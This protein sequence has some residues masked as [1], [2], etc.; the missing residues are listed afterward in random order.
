MNKYD[1]L[2]RII[3]QNVGGKDNVIGLT[4]CVT[5]LRFKLK[6]ESKAN[7][8][9]LKK[10]DG[11][12]TVIQSGGQYQV[13]IGNH[14][15]DVFDA[16]NEIGGFAAKGGED[17][18]KEK[19]S[20]GAAFIDMISGIFAPTLGV[21][22]ATGMIKGL[23]AMCTFFKILE[24]TSGTYQILYAAADS[25]F[26]FLP[27]LL[28]FTA[29]KKFGLNHFTGMAIAGAL[30]YPN[31]VALS[32]GEVLSTVFSGTM[33]ET[34]VYTKFLG[35]PVLLPSGGYASTV[36]PIIA[37]VYIASKL[38]KLFKKI[39]PDVVK[40]FLVPMCVLLVAVPV[41]F[42]LIG[43]VANWASAIVGSTTSWLYN[44]SPIIEGIFVG[45]FWQIFVMFGLH[46]GLIPIFILNL[47][48]KG[49]DDVLQPFFVASF[50]QTAVVLAMLIKTKDKKLKRL[51]I[52]AFI[53][54][55]FGV[56]EPAI[57]GIT[58]PRKKPFVIS[59]IGGAIGGGIMG[60]ANVN[61]YML[62]GMGVFG[63]PNYINPATND[64]SGLV[65]AAVAVAVGTV[66]SFILTM[67][68]YKD[69][70][71]D[72]SSNTISTKA[73]AASKPGETLVSPVAGTVKDL[74]QVSD[75]A[76][77]QGILG[78]G[79]AIT[80]S[81]GKIYAP[82]D[83]V[84]TTFFPTG[85]A[86]GLTTNNGAELLIHVGMDTVQLEGKFFQP[87]AKQ[88]D[89]VTAGQLLLEFDVEAIKAAGYSVDTPIIVTNTE[90]YLDV[91]PCGTGMVKKGA[92]LIKLL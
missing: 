75:E 85:H 13:V 71:E 80:P 24:A 21:L 70:V 60:F 27:I 5:R 72:T 57:Y 59:C 65:W 62:G 78:K 83:G 45:A 92:E 15:P 48:T 31:I 87:K 12:V 22:C 8:D 25:F 43:P 18:P 26:Y 34:A 61:A 82:A 52:P 9:V 16:V 76:F 11:I 23:L 30:V 32:S 84:I 28:G 2:A 90:Q 33:F 1:G 19:L 10:T 3:I 54:G 49:F 86:I 55:I 88:G 81:E 36:I 17:A 37:A 4:H 91:V 66:V 20:I 77:S 63:F 14:V 64:A 35:I 42:L 40:T 69:D 89:A 73:G 51:A 67:M 53:S 38:E 39:I 46:W 74:K 29:S 41:T 44:L 47:T 58:L 79:I 68:L 50:A 7:T 6:D 56:T